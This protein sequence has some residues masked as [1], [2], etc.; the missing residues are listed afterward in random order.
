MT[1]PLA[2]RRRYRYR[3]RMFKNFRIAVLLYILLFVALG[4]YLTSTRS[5]NWDAS[6]WVDVYAVNATGDTG[7]EAFIERL[8]SDSFAEIERF[9]SAQAKSYGVGIERPFRIELAGQIDASL[10]AIPEMSAPL[11]TLIW[12]L[13]MRWFVTRLH[14]TSDRPTPDIT[15]FA[16]YHSEDAKIVMDRS[17]A[18]RKGMIAIANLF[19]GQR[20]QVSNRFIVAHELLHTLGATD[21]Y[22]FATNGPIYPIGYAAL[23]RSP[24]YR[25][26]DAEIMAGRIPISANEAVMPT[27]LTQVTVGPVTA[28]EIGWISHLPP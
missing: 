21:K 25:Q 18:L 11:E 8:T 16:V 4:Q 13:R 17:T 20:S 24:R 27:G 9:Y 28:H 7:T 3:Y 5:T 10:P 1:V 6:L 12:S 26:G 23:D 2:R 22:D 15:L 14:W 19:A